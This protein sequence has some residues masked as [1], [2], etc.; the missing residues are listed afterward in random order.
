MRI[1][2][3]IFVICQALSGAASAKCA[4]AR[5]EVEGRIVLPEDVDAA[6]L[7]LYLFLEGMP[8]PSDY[9][10]PE[11]RRD[12][13]VPDSAGLFKAVAW[14]NTSSGYSLLTGDRCRRVATTADLVL[15]GKGIRARRVTVRFPLSRREIRQRLGA[16]AKVPDVLL[17]P[18]G[19]SSTTP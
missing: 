6:D 19:E 4:F 12:Y 1:A 9:P 3:A 14:M 2:L 7:R 15:L 17:E 13:A 8:Y 5:Y 16:K 18:W 11:P 10:P